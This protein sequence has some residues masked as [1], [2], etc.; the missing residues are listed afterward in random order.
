MRPR[1]AD[2]WFWGYFAAKFD[3]VGGIYKIRSPLE[4]VLVVGYISNA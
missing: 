4:G 2:L 1:H 3:E